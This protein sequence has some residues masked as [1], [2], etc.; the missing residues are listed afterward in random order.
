M[1]DKQINQLPSSASVQ[2][3]DLFVLQRNGVAYN[4]KGSAIGC[5]YFSSQVV[6]A[7]SSGTM[8]TISDNNI[9][10]NSVVLECTFADP[11]LITSDITWTSSAGRIVFTGTCTAATTANVV[12]ANKVN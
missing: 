4:A 1:A 6:S 7:A 12:I 8:L 10:T 2:A 9:T 11:V 5:L 3:G